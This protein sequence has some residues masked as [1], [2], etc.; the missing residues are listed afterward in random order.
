[1]WLESKQRGLH[2][3]IMSGAKGRRHLVAQVLSTA[4]WLC[5]GFICHATHAVNNGSQLLMYLLRFYTDDTSTKYNIYKE[6]L[7]GASHAMQLASY[8]SE[9]SRRPKTMQLT[10]LRELKEVKKFQYLPHHSSDRSHRYTIWNISTV[11]FKN[12]RGF[13][14]VILYI[15]IRFSNG[16]YTLADIFWERKHMATSPVSTQ[17][18]EGKKKLNLI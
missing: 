10:I 1:M 17:H 14:Y 8:I 13:Y 7:P 5:L 9:H 2:G 16:L 11:L 18:F 15:C 3:T 12:G 4:L 6:P